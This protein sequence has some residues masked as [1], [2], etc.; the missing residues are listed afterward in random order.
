LTFFAL[1]QALAFT[2]ATSRFDQMYGRGSARR[3]HDLPWQKF[4]PG[5]R[6]PRRNTRKINSFRDRNQITNAHV[7]FTSVNSC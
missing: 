7:Q 3:A 4:H 5:I 6:Q 1:H 2:R